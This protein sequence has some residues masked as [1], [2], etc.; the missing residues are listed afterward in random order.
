[1]S[2]SNS[3]DAFKSYWDCALIDVVRQLSAAIAACDDGRLKESKDHLTLQDIRRCLSSQ[4][5]SVVSKP[6]SNLGRG[7]LLDD[8]K[9]SLRALE[10][11]Q[12]ELK[13]LIRSKF[14][15]V[16]F[17]KDELKVLSA[18]TEDLKAH[19]GNL[20]V[21]WDQLFGLKQMLLAPDEVLQARRDW[22]IAIVADVERSLREAIC[23][24]V[25][26]LGHSDP[27]RMAVVKTAKHLSLTLSAQRALSKVPSL[28]IVAE[29]L[30]ERMSESVT[31]TFESADI[32]LDS[33]G[34]RSFEN[35]VW[36]DGFLKTF[37]RLGSDRV[38]ILTSL[39]KFRQ[40]CLH[41][42]HAGLGEE[43]DAFLDGT[44]DLKTAAQ[45]L[46]GYGI[47]YSLAVMDA[48]SNGPSIDQDEKQV[49]RKKLA[50][51]LHV[52]NL[53]LLKSGLL[54]LAWS[55]AEFVHQT[56]E[57]KSRLMLLFNAGFAR[58]RLNCFD[59]KQI[60]GI[61]VD[62]KGVAVR[63]KILKKCLLCEWGGIAKLMEEA[64]D[65]GDVTVHEF[66]SWPALEDLRARKEFNTALMKFQG[67]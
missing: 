11:L 14:P 42:L 53:T 61:D 57:D 9:V 18:S 30:A 17:N 45:L 62:A 66:E 38:E 27:V 67:R 35:S 59:Y 65:S 12:Q 23:E 58:K 7:H 20:T 6:E 31:D 49:A 50:M 28:D 22:Y 43:S 63:Y 13:N 46:Y 51:E 48:V 19:F 10:W 54:W 21:G 15:N 2:N 1:V 26:W 44:A 33:F 3:R 29:V 40:Q 36:R 8:D 39:V 41:P 16:T 55:T 37:K 60:R 4:E 24:A 34:E 25:K 64:L 56:Y 47:E 32:F 52:A 5:S